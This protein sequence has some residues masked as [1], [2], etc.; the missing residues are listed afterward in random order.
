M[1]S[2][3]DVVRAWKD[4]RYRHNLSQEKLAELPAHP[5]GQIELAR[6]DLLPYKGP[7]LFSGED[8]LDTRLICSLV[9]GCWPITITY[10]GGNA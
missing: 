7:A 9:F 6:E 3:V 10:R 8:C 5:A 4:E 2:T 1:L